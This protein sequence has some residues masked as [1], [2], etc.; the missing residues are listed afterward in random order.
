MKNLNLNEQ[1]KQRGWHGFCGINHANQTEF[2]AD[3]LSA[4]GRSAV[5]VT[6][7][8]FPANNALITRLSRANHA[9][10]PL[11]RCVNT[12]IR[13]G[14][15]V[16]GG[17]A[18]RGAGKEVVAMM[19]QKC[20]MWKYAATVVLMLTLG[21]G[22]MWGE[23]VKYVFLNPNGWNKDG[24]WY[25]AYF[26]KSSN[27]DKYWS[28]TTQVPNTGIW[29]AAVPDGYDKMIWVRMKSG[30]SLS[31]DNQTNWNNKW[32][33]S[34][35]LDVPDVGSIAA[36]IA[37]SG[38]N[39]AS[40]GDAGHD[41]DVGKFYY[42]EAGTTVYFDNTDA[43]FS[44]VHMRLGRHGLDNYADGNNKYRYTNDYTMSLVSGTKA[45][46]KYTFESAWI[47]YEAFSFGNNVGATGGYSVYNMSS[48]DYLI[49]KSTEFF[50]TNLN[51]SAFTV[52][53]GSTWNKK[54]N[55]T[56][57][58][59]TASSSRS[60]LTYT[61]TNRSVDHATVELY[62]WDESNTRQTV[63][64]GAFANV[65][66]TTKVWCKVT[67]DEGYV[68]S[69]VNLYDPTVREWK[70]A[71]REDN[72]FEK[73]CYVVRTNVEFEAVIESYATQTVLIKDENGWAPNMYFKG[74]NP[75]RYDAYDNAQY[76][77]TTQK[78]SDKITV[79][80]DDYYVV[81]FTNEYPFYY[82]HNEG[83]LSRTAFFTPSR[84]THM[85]KY[86]DATAG[87]DDWGLATSDC[88]N[89]IYWVETSKGGKSYISN[90]VAST[91]EK[92]S[93]YVPSGGTVDFHKSAHS[94]V[95]QY[96][97]KFASFF[98]AG[99]AL[100][101]K[102]GGVFTAE[103]DGTDLTDVAVYNGDYH[104][105]VNATTRNY[106]TAGASKD[107]T[108]GTKFTYFE[109]NALFGDLYNY[110]WVDWFLGSSDSYGAQS[111]VATVGN[112]YNANLAG[113]LGADEFAPKG[114]TQAAGGNVRYGY[115]PE[116]NYF[117]RAIIAAGDEAVKISSSEAG[118]VMIS[119]DGGSTYTQDASST[120]CYLADMTNWNYQAY[121]QVKGQATATASTS[122]VSGT[123]NLATNKK[124]IGG[125][126]GDTYT[127]V[128][129]YDFKTDRFVA[130]WNPNGAS[131]T[132]F[133][134][135]SNLMAVRTENGSPAVLN[136]QKGDLDDAKITLSKITKIY[137]V[138]EFLQDNWLDNTAP[139]AYADRRIVTGNYVDEYYWI[140][141]PYKCY[142]GDIFGIEGY[143]DSW[144]LQTYHGDYRAAQGWWAETDTWWYDMDRTDTLQANQ[145]YVLRVTN[146]N[147]DNS[148][149]G[150]PKRFAGDSGS[151]L[152]LY[153]PSYGDNLSIALAK[154][155]GAV[156][157]SITSKVP[158][159]ICSKVRDEANHA[160]DPNYDRRAIDSNWNIIG[161]PSFNSTKITTDTWGSTYP[162][163]NIT[164]ELK[165]FYTWAANTDPKYQ[166]KA[167]SGFSTFEF[168]ATHAYLVQYAGDITWQ[169][170]NDSNPL[171]GVKAPA[172]D[173]EEQGDRTLKMVLNKDGEQADVTYI[174]QMA[175][176]AT[177]G[178]DLNLDLS[179]LLSNSGNNL[180]TLA[181][182]YK[183]AGNCLPETTTTVPVGVQ[184]AAEGEYT[185]SIPEG[186]NGTGAVLIDNTA[187]TRTNLALTDYTVQL[188]A[189]QTDNRFVLELSPISNVA[190]EIENVQGDNVQ[191]TN[192]Q[193]RI[194][195]GVLYIVKNGQ[196]FDA[197][198][199]KVK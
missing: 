61:I 78:I 166:I 27:D 137:I 21:V 177:E 188:P 95:D 187:G 163:S 133:D 81:T 143:G 94:P 6:L 144:V 120:T 124:L 191:G 20:M 154:S 104:I 58:Y 55:S 45:L 74:W 109:P 169:K 181:G 129:T 107:G 175:E 113:I 47:G 1:E 180:Y 122:Y 184:I 80:G 174:S 195:D 46:Y 7:E 190:T 199:N 13:I 53:G 139:Y 28:G 115:N 136:I 44:S 11:S 152:Y 90:V 138:M 145:G 111:V 172:R 165:F 79:C 60:R 128:I 193:K 86:T 14:D 156:A 147:G 15:Y 22:E 43:G 41:S 66:P 194:V 97:A 73:N 135:E 186:T 176:G 33:N 196:V 18:R 88:S 19:R 71:S 64:E 141:L 37:Y 2:Q 119:T 49:S 105:H 134:L 192:A 4:S 131:I 123:Q 127:V 84:L 148:V 77:Y 31:M 96:S 116:T 48:G 82:I 171:V 132:G 164:G 118:K 9:L 92:L 179:K 26:Y 185:F 170:W 70:D 106:L 16:V 168:Q 178:Y 197:R 24:A 189:G 69:K 93:F 68:V 159:H 65:L 100:E 121:A 57:F 51:A 162:T 146:L 182:Y 59:N 10:L 76:Y 167:A 75:F 35:N 183:M 130:A 36:W 101:G 108:T 63:A 54:E 110:Y 32:N 126:V 114:M 150:L 87:D 91:D 52:I 198:G 112:E 12:L 50:R 3:T 67:P 29:Y 89:D 155:G 42:V 62:Y 151:K 117:D 25:A 99:G 161:S 149:K 40:L 8:E 157:E 173:N 39:V 140:S 103:T 38:D 98:G 56:D 102:A 158:K 23:K 125:A 153:F 34:G 83:D 85:A 5:S 160:G 30:S 142:I 72:G 17:R